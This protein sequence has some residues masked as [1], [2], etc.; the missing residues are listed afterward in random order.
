MKYLPSIMISLVLASCVPV[1]T[2]TDTK[3]QKKLVHDDLNYEPAIGMVQL[4]PYG[5]NLSNTLQYPTLPISNTSG[6]RLEFDLLQK[7]A[8]YVNVRYIHCNYDWRKS[9]LN[10]IQFL[11]E[12]NEFSVDE[13]NFS[14]NA[15]EQ[16]VKY[17]ATLPTPTK[18]GNYI[19]VAYRNSDKSDLL[20]TRRFLVYDGGVSIEGS[21][22]ASNMVSKRNQNQQIEFQVQYD[23]LDNINPYN[24]IKVTVL[25]N[26]NWHTEITG[27]Q[28]TNIRMSEGLLIYEHFNGENNFPAWNEFRF[29]DLR[30]TE[31][32]GMNVAN[33]QYKENEV[34]AF[35]SFDKSRKG[36][37][38]TQFQDDMNGGYYL[39]NRD[40]ND[41]QLESE[42]IKVHF[43]LITEPINGDVYI[44]GRHNNWDLSPN[45]RMY[46]DE[47]VGSYKGQLL[48]KQGYYDY[49]YWVSSESLPVT[50]FEGSHFQAINNYEILVYYRSPFNNYDQLIGYRLISSRNQF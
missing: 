7:N 50:Y 35:L 8:D 2:T 20:F 3:S 30:S 42:Y 40:P 22:R 44:A 46:Y 26:H 28:P 36:L 18:S 1:S 5:E 9:N 15:R 38:Y 11:D 21:V 19:L 4:Y 14:Q 6:L 10:D 23:G 45:N 48:L 43:E 47:A 33:V 34:D 29:F 24:D 13:Y 17:G 25:Q 39:E 31:Y 27:L 49:L 32:R 41:S 16:Y 12:Y 37:A